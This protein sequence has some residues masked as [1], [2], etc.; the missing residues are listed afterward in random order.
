MARVRRPVNTPS[1]PS[2]EMKTVAIIGVVLVLGVAYWWANRED[3]PESTG[4]G[5]APP[6]AIAK[7]ALEQSAH[8]GAEAPVVLVKF[9][10]F[11]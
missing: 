3:A 1:G 8:G 9:T 6:A 10:D 2:S 5:D 11:Q 7:Y 4:G